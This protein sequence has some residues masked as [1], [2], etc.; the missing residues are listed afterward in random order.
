M[1]TKV[2]LLASGSAE[3]QN[4]EDLAYFLALWPPP[5][6]HIRTTFINLSL[7]YGM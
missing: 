6:K 4:Y 5:A 3:I 2:K 1:R 7:Y